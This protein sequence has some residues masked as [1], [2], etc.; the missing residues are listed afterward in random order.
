[1]NRELTEADIKTCLLQVPG[2]FQV[3]V[4]FPGA[5]GCYSFYNWGVGP[6]LSITDTSGRKKIGEKI[7]ASIDT[8]NIFFREMVGKYG[9]DRVSIVCFVDMTGIGCDLVYLDTVPRV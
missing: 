7:P 9:S 6:D 2:G 8:V 3:E 1:M 5:N 4:R